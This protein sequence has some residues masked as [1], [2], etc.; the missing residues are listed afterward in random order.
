[1]LNRPIYKERYPE[2]LSY[3]LKNIKALCYNRS[4][5]AMAIVT[6]LLTEVYQNYNTLDSR[7]DRNLCINSRA[8]HLKENIF[9]DESFWWNVKSREFSLAEPE[10]IENLELWIECK[11]KLDYTSDWSTLK[12]DK[13]FKRNLLSIPSAINVIKQIYSF[14]DIKISSSCSSLITFLIKLISSDSVRRILFFIQ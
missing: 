3:T 2:D 1:M 6:Q 7:L 5:E 14:G 8:Q 10:K 11:K 9:W 4:P 12:H 13:W